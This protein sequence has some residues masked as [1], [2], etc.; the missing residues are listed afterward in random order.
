MY[1]VMQARMNSS[2]H[3]ISTKYLG[4]GMSLGIQQKATSAMKT[5]FTNIPHISLLSKRKVVALHIQDYRN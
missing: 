4:A 3:Y 2:V 5:L 1:K